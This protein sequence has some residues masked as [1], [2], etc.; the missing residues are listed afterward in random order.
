MPELTFRD[1]HIG[2]IADIVTLYHGG[3]VRGADTP[4]LDPK[5]LKDPRYRAA[6]EEIEND[7]NQLLIVVEIDDDIVGTLQI[8]FIRGLS[9]FGELRGHL[10]HVHI[11]E[12]LRGSGIGT[13]MIEWA[14]ECC[15]DAG[16]DLVQLTSNKLRTDAH[17]FYE[18]IGFEKTHE[19]F[20]LRF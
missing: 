7:P 1:A 14:L 4:P 6:F 20:K 5:T 10:E 8:T 2:D 9:R 11:R 13:E 16:C 18:R 3:D 12:D 15:R 19:G 17:R